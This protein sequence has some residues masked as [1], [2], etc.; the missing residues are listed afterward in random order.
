LQQTQART[1]IEALQSHPQAWEKVDTILQHSQS[2]QSKFVALQVRWTSAALCMHLILL[3]S[4]SSS[5]LCRAAALQTVHLQAMLAEATG[6]A[7]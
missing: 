4:A 1:A 7:M 2:E 3:T 6:A 5:A